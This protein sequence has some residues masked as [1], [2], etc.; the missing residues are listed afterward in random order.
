MIACADRP[1]APNA[2][3]Y[4]PVTIIAP[5]GLIVNARHP[6]P[7]AHRIS[8]CHVMLNVLFG[9]LAQ[10]V[11]DR[12]PAAYY[13][14]SYVC[15]FQTVNADARKVLVEIEVGGCGGHPVQDGA[16]AFSFGMHNNASIPIE[17]IESD[18]PLTITG[19]GL[20]PDTGGAGVH[21]G[22]LGLFREWRIESERA[23]FTGQM[24]RFRTRPYGL[25]GG[26]PGAVGTLTLIR[27]GTKDAASFQ[28]RQYAAAKGRCHSSRNI[29][30]RRPWRSEEPG[31][32]RREDRSRTGICERESGRELRRLTFERIL[33]AQNNASWLFFR[34]VTS[35]LP[36]ACVIAKGGRAAAIAACGV[37][38]RPRTPATLPLAPA[39]RRRNP[40]SANP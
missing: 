5:E 30:R 39:R 17:M 25:A 13:A 16:S 1:I 26:Q 4:R 22:G 23:T 37:T 7:V 32:R 27:N 19:Y 10:V 8:P 40:A 11:P 3:C 20:L 21:R 24:D 31:A 28:G 34:S 36:G 35:M 38:R 9:A 29:R 6:S 14:V 12:I 15:S 33:A 2:G 18:T